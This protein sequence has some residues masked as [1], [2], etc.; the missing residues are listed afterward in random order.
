MLTQERL[1]ELLSYD[2]ETGLFTWLSQHGARVRTGSVAGSRT[3]K[4][5]I[6]IGVDGA[7]YMAHRLA[8]LYTYGVWPPQ[9]ID[10]RDGVRWNNVLSNL[11]LATPS[12]NSQNQR[13]A[14]RD[15]TSGFLGVSRAGKKWKGQITYGGEN[16]YLG[17]FDTAEQAHAA[18]LAAK[19]AQH[20]HQTLVDKAA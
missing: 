5:Y 12:Q 15:G 14:H 1:K 9:E 10:H 2:P 11:R 4:R 16:V 19:A 3:V 13:G 6:R 8:W 20:P 18:Y 7:L 17:R